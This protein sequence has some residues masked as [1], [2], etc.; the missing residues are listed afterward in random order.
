MFKGQNRILR[1][2]VISRTG[3]T[4][5]EH[6]I[7]STSHT[8]TVDTPLPLTLP[9]TQNTQVFIH[10]GSKSNNRLKYQR[11]KEDTSKA[12][13]ASTPTE[14]FQTNTSATLCTK[15]TYSSRVQDQY[16]NYAMKTW[17]A[18]SSQDDPWSS[19]ARFNA[20]GKTADSFH[21][22]QQTSDISLGDGMCHDISVLSEV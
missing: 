3:W 20:N 4:M 22:E 7:A 10:M 11:A 12:R 5:D 18:Q 21:K 1:P 16:G 17:L 2:V 9:K 15:E 6:I 14:K 19:V 8:G 13:Y